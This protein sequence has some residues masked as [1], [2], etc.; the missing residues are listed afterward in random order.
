MEQGFEDEESW[1]QDFKSS[2]PLADEDLQT[3]LRVAWFFF[4]QTVV[5]QSLSNA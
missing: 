1:S 5:L 3:S 4:F 2:G